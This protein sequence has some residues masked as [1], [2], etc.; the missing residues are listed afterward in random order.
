[1][2]PQV[3]TCTGKFVQMLS[4]FVAVVFLPAIWVEVSQTEQKAD[5]SHSEWPEM[6]NQLENLCIF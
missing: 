5:F 6:W 4:Q 2:T 3:V 1:M